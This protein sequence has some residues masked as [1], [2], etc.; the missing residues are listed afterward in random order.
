MAYRRSVKRFAPADDCERRPQVGGDEATFRLAR[1]VSLPWSEKRI[2]RLGDRLEAM[3]NR[4]PAGWPS[5]DS[6][7]ELEAALPLIARGEISFR[8]I[9]L[10]FAACERAAAEAPYHTRAESAEHKQMKCAARWWMRWSGAADASYEVTRFGGRADVASIRS[11]WIVECGH[12]RMGKL[13]DAI[14]QLPDGRFTLLPYQPVERWDRT[15]RRL[16]AIDFSWTASASEEVGRAIDEKRR[17]AADSVWEKMA[18]RS[19]VR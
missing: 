19:M 18:H 5:R 7:L 16:L 14:A 11:N 4:I 17:A 6:W 10:P 1:H 12:T 15:A 13:A 9:R 3:F 2:L 8:L